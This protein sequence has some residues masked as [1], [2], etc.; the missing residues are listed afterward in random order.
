MVEFDSLEGR[1]PSKPA[2]KNIGDIDNS[3]RISN[4]LGLEAVDF[5]HDDLLSSNGS[6]E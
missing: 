5:D 1:G 4:V 2:S 6:E 3:I